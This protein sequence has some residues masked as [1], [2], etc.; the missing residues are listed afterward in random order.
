[1]KR[2][3]KSWEIKYQG[4]DK[5]GSYWM[6]ISPPGFLEKGT[7]G[8]PDRRHRE[9][10]SSLAECKKYIDKM[11][12]NNMRRNP[13]YKKIDYFFNGKYEG[14]TNSY[15]TCKDAKE[16]L[17]TNYAEQVRRNISG[18]SPKMIEHFKEVVRSPEKL[19]CFF[20][21]DFKA[22][23]NP[24]CMR[25]NPVRLHNTFQ[26]DIY[27]TSFRNLPR[28][29][30]EVLL[31]TEPELEKSGYTVYEYMGFIRNIV[32]FDGR[33]F[34]AEI[35]LGSVD[36]KNSDYQYDS[37]NDEYY[38]DS[39]RI[40]DA[41]EYAEQMLQDLYEVIEIEN[42]DVYLT[43]IDE[44]RIKSKSNPIQDSQAVKFYAGE[45]VFYAML[46]PKLISKLNEY[47][48]NIKVLD[49]Y[50]ALH[51]AKQNDNYLGFI[52]SKDDFDKMLRKIEAYLGS[53][54]QVD[55]DMAVISNPTKLSMK[56]KSNPRFATTMKEFEEAE[57]IL[58]TFIKNA[59]GKDYAAELISQ[60]IHG[61]LEEF[62]ARGL[63]GYMA[64]GNREALIFLDDIEEPFSLYVDYYGD[65]PVIVW[66]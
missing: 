20:D 53:D 15:P 29:V 46:D 11:S 45:N 48:K 10:L 37:R 1:M 17:L 33:V 2:K 8:D 44:P 43:E 6:A 58:A 21:P 26:P 28:D 27:Y 19:K 55:K 62:T 52:L 61:E 47:F 7:T 30:Q 63:K 56:S 54:Y 64:Y 32:R 13:N 65:R 25:K 9:I 23:R 60:E 59:G 16:A 36:I 5:Q 66:G 38:D 39:G 50:H 41:E 42:I 49:D 18:Y 31:N 12:E 34:K 35:T 3:Y 51:Y 22:R 4:R 57:K 24:S 40:I 14:S